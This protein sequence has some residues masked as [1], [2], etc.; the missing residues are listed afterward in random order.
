[1]K[2][3]SATFAANDTACRKCG[4]AMPRPQP[5]KGLLSGSTFRTTA[6]R[7]SCGHWND[8]RKR[9]ANH[10]AVTPTPGGG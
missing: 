1:M 6:Y 7:C 8:L 2:H 9:K 3:D 4:A 5:A 10:G